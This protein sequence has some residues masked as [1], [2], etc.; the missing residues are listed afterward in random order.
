MNHSRQLVLFFIAVFVLV[1]VTESSTLGDEWRGARHAKT[2]QIDDS[3]D[4]Y[5]KSLTPTIWER[6]IPEYRTFRFRR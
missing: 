4:V 2:K 6:M 1:I 5:L 3:I